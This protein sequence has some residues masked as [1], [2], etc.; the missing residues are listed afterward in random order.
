MFTFII[1]LD[2]N[3][4][5]HE[6]T[7][8]TIC[9]TSFLFFSLVS[10]ANLQRGQFH[11]RLPGS[12]SVGRPH[13]ITASTVTSQFTASTHE[14]LPILLVHAVISPQLSL[15]PTFPQILFFKNCLPGRSIQRKRKPPF[16][17]CCFLY[18]FLKTLFLNV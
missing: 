12:V 6:I 18:C 14:V 5:K 8:Q 9:D 13:V 10:A 4:L 1:V 3:V 11:S 2:V 15:F 16:Q 7:Y 17:M